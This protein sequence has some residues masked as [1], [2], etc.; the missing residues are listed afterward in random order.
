MALAIAV[1][2]VGSVAVVDVTGRLVLGEECSIVREK[3]RE[4]LAS[5]QKNIL[6]NLSEVTYADSAGLG[7]LVASHVTVAK[8]GGMLKIL[9]SQKK[10]DGL[11]E[12]TR[13]HTIFQVFADQDLAILSF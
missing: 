3:I 11:L 4:L 13:L 5:G 10:L 1:R 12:L 8:A 2:Q 9:N 6:L 7:E